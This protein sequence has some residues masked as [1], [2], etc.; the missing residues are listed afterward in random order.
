MPDKSDSS[1]LHLVT[2]SDDRLDVSS[3]TSTREY[4][5][6]RDKEKLFTFLSR[7]DALANEY[8]IYIKNTHATGTL[9]ISNITFGTTSNQ[10]FL[11]H[12]VTGT[13][14]G[15]TITPRSRNY[16][17]TNT[18]SGT[19]YGGAKVTGL[20]SSWEAEAIRVPAND[21]KIWHNSGGIILNNGEALAVQVVS[22]GNASVTVLGYCE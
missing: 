5:N 11:I 20:T 18:C 7:V 22:A 3:R 17:E 2:G 4:Y 15:T 8:V 14:G 16:A 10:E 9:F 6:N 12:K 1:V 19:F 13:P 21:S